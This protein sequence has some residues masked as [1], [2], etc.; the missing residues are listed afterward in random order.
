[1]KTVGIIGGLGPESTVDYYR[2]IIAE[3][4]KRI[5]DGSYPPIVINSIDL[6]KLLDLV[7]AGAYAALTAWLLEEVHRLERAGADFGLLASNT[8]HLVFDELRLHSP[9]PLISIVEASCETA[10]SRGLRTLGLLGSRFTMQ[11]DFYPKVFSKAGI[12]LI[13]PQAVEQAYIHDKYMGELVKGVFLPETRQGLLQIVARLQREGG[14]EGVILGG[15]EL[16]LILRGAS[17]PGVP[18]LDTAQIHV[19]AVVTELLQS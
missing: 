4:R 16:P 14:I 2:L 5:P 11:A 1:M 15:T 13:V 17:F 7:E 6:K 18:F 10:R 12:R 9:I 8:P 19:Q 3:Y